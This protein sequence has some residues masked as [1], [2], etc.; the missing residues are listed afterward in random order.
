[1]DNITV[2]YKKRATNFETVIFDTLSRRMN[3]L[4]VKEC[5]DLIEERKRC[6]SML[7]A[8]HI[9]LPHII[10][11]NVKQCEIFIINLEH[12]LNDDRC[13]IKTII[14][15]LVNDAKVTSEQLM[16]IEKLMYAIADDNF[17]KQIIKVNE[18]KKIRKII[19]ERIC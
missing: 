7:V 2:E 1:M 12:F 8:N 3:L 16:T 4:Q 11:N 18:V 14:L 13:E 19:E 5:I 15:I 17:C 6:G 9:L 10:T